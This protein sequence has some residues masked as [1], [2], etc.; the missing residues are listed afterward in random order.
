MRRAK[1]KQPGS[2]HRVV[3]QRR[4]IRGGHVVSTV[5]ED[6]GRCAVHVIAFL[7]LGNQPKGEQLMKSREKDGSNRSGSM[8]D[9]EFG[10]WMMENFE[11]LMPLEAEL[12]A[13]GRLL[14]ERDDDSVLYNASVLIEE[15]RKRHPER[16]TKAVSNA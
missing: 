4:N 13:A 5:H 1:Q 2:S 14:P 10:T 3:D 7:F 12:R 15:F 16:D 9:L 6:V 8:T 11:L